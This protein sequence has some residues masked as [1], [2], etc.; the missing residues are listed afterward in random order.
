MG[1]FRV[2]VQAVGGHGCQREIKDGEKVDGC[3]QPSCPDCV[4]REYVRKLKEIGT[5]F[6]GSEGYAKLTH[7][8]GQQGEVR[9]DLLTG[10][11]SGNF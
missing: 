10:I 7:W 8:P 4:T 6:D 2:E 5:Y 11:R 1:T 9:D 3:G